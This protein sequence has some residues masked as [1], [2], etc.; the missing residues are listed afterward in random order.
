MEEQVRAQ[1]ERVAAL[2]AG[3]GDKTKVLGEVSAVLTMCAIINALCY[4]CGTGSQ[5]AAAQE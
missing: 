3:G 5:A 1:E 2:R 4:I